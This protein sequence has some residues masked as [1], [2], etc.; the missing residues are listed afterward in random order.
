MNLI[1]RLLLDLGIL[2]RAEREDPKIKS[3]PIAKKKLTKKEVF[4]NANYDRDPI[5]APRRFVEDDD[6]IVSLRQLLPIVVIGVVVMGLLIWASSV[7]VWSGETPEKKL[8]A[9]WQEKTHAM[10]CI[11]LKKI[12]EEDPSNLP[13]LA[14]QFSYWEYMSSQTVYPSPRPVG[15][16]HQ[17]TGYL[18]KDI[19]RCGKYNAG[20]GCKTYYFPRDETTKTITFP[21]GWFY[22]DSITDEKFTSPNSFIA[23]YY[24]QLS[25]WHVVINGTG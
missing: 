15:E 20:F 11:N 12:I 17:Q 3:R 24:P 7:F 5:Q 9:E 19:E 25:D 10:S 6:S 16:C 13:S 14:W 2:R 18:L 4:E 22:I 21:H 23:N 1:V 8:R